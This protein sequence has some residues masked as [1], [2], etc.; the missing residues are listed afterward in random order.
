MALSARPGRGTI[1]IYVVLT[2]GQRMLIQMPTVLF[3]KATEVDPDAYGIVP[4]AYGLLIP[5]GYSRQG[6]RMRQL[7]LGRALR[8]SRQGHRKRQL[9]LGRA[10]RLGTRA[11]VS[12]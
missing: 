11:P 4:E 2:Q 1:L 10:L 7:I 3:Q 6:H 5:K 8:H 12:L 9:I